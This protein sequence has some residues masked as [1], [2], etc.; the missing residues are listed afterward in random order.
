MPPTAGVSPAFYLGDSFIVGIT[1]PRAIGIYARTHILYSNSFPEGLS[2]S[3]RST[4]ISSPLQLKAL[5]PEM[6][7]QMLHTFKC[8]IDI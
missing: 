5:S 4:G 7:C 2:L 8:C 1:L 3:A 6:V